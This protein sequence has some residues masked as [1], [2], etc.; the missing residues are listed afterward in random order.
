[1]VFL[2]CQTKRDAKGLSGIDGTLQ[3]IAAF[4]T[5][6]AYEQGHAALEKGEIEALNE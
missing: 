4:V 1:M 6:N 3:K 5:L 2:D